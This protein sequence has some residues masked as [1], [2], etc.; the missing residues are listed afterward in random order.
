MGSPTDQNGRTALHCQGRRCFVAC[1]VGF[2]G[3]AYDASY[4]RAEVDKTIVFQSGADGY[5]TYRIPVIVKAANGDLLAFAEGRKNGGGD[6]GDIDIVMKRSTNNGE[7]WSA[8]SLVQDE[9]ANPTANV[10][11]GNP[12]PVVDMLDPAHPGRVWL[13]FSRNNSRVFVTY[14]DDNG[15]TWSTRTEIT[16]TAKKPEW[17]WYATGPVHGIQLERGAHEGRLIIPSDHRLAGQDSWGAHVLMSDDHGATWTVGGV[18]TRMVAD[19]MHPNEN[20]AVELV[21]GRVYINARDQNGSDPA[22]RLVAYSN[23]GGTTY[24]APFTAAPEFTTPVVQNSLLRFAA[25][26]RGDDLNVLVWSGPGVANARRD[27]TIMV[28][29]D[30]A[31][32]W[33]QKTLLHEGPTAYSDMVKLDSEQIG[34]IYEAGQTLYNQIVFASFT[35]N[36]LTPVAWNGVPGDVNQDGD[37]TRDDVDAFVSVWKPFDHAPLLGGRQSYINGDLDFDGAITIG[38]AMAL[39]QALLANGL[40]TSG[41]NRLEL[42]PEPSTLLLTVACGAAQLVRQLSTLLN[43]L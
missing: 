9:W 37:L 30:E 25:K 42:V 39:R 22:S 17:S 19:P 18:D 33:T 15:A 11:I 41:L 27:L 29:V 35:L 13:P 26:D 20:T 16:A 23:D 4:A 5:H 7:S 28:S 34:V 21:D 12:S 10:T 24:A 43:T 32:S 2:L 36:D 14:S 38:D 6:A 1:L 3:A 8:M 40:P 31:Q